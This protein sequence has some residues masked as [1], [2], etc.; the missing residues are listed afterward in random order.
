MNDYGTAI[1]SITGTNAVPV[2]WA[3]GC[4]ASSTG[5]VGYH[6]TDATLSGGST[7]FAPLDSYAGLESTPR[8]V[9]YSPIPA[10]DTH[11][12]VYRVRVYGTQ[13]AAIYTTE[14][15]YIA[16]PAY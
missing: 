12:I 14:I 15:V 4:L 11:D 1:P 7:R 9:M 3:I 6:T 5:C 10:D 8:E 2:S 13:P 16:V